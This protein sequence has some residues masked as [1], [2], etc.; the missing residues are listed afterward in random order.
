MQI[1]QSLGQRWRKDVFFRLW[2]SIVA[3]LALVS[4][5]NTWLNI[6]ALR[7][8][9]STQLNERVENLTNVLVK[10]LA[11]PLFD[12]N[13]IA[14]D[15]VSD[16]VA[17]D[18]QILSLQVTSP[19]GTVLVKS[20]S[21]QK[22]TGR[23]VSR[24]RQVT[25]VTFDKTYV[26]GQLAVFLSA[27]DIEKKLDW[28]IFQAVIS[29]VLL[30]LVMTLALFLAGRKLSKN[31][32][33]LQRAV[34]HLARGDTHIAL[35]NLGHEDQM[36]RMS[37]AVE[38]FRTT[39]IQ[40]RDVEHESATLL[41]EKSDI[42]GKLN[43]IYD[44]SN[45]AVMLLTERGFFDCN[46]RAMEMFGVSEKS[47]FV[48]LHPSDISPPAQPDG[49]TSRAA[50]EEKIGLAFQ[51]G[52]CRF[53]WLHAKRDGSVFPAEV[54]LSAFVYGGQ[55]VLQATVRDITARKLI[56]S[57]LLDL[58][59]ALESKIELRTQEIR[60]T[61]VLLAQSQ[62]T[63]QGI[64]D[65]ALDAVIR[66]NV[67]GIIVGWN[68]QAS[69]IFGWSAQEALGRTLHETIIPQQHRQRHLQGMARFL[70]TGQSKVIDQ[71]IEI[72]ALH[73]SG[74]EFP[75]E[76]ALTQVA[77]QDS[78][79]VEFCAFI[80]DI[81]QRKRAEEEIRTSLEKQR[82]L[83]QLKSRFVA[84]ASH[85]FRTP[86]ATILSSTDLLN[87]YLDRL[88][89]TERDGLFHSITLAVER[90][91]KMLEDILTIGMDDA[92]R[93][94]FNPAPMDIALFCRALVDEVAS[95]QGVGE[96][97]RSAIE[98][99]THGADTQGLFDATLM[100]HILEN[101][102]SNAQKYSPDGQM[103]DFTLDCGPDAFVFTVADRGIGVPQA[104]MPRL[105]ESFHRASNVGTIIGT[106]LGL[107][108]VKR[109]VTLHTGTIA[110]SSVLGEGTV[111]LV[112]IPRSIR[113]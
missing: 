103:I 89:P 2:T 90:M 36:G 8:D 26:V 28:Q 77:L 27:E 39:I 83:V 102:L 7:A 86:L 47:Q 66:A 50:S 56:E 42:A 65:T 76:L 44:G 61:L 17:L 30:V 3:S 52:E 20:G 12:I 62:Q 64:V 70:P 94:Q 82:E 53:E 19:D 105:F 35:P 21:G 109:S 5:V 1:R 96:S 98:F 24:Q 11:R 68:A 80:R 16:A 81:T 22:M 95:K 91:T 48:A 88:P 67:H 43:A 32:G 29:G 33:E 92:E 74:R 60:S 49:Q 15:S 18:P 58:N 97:M 85:E 38:R 78:G 34:D 41:A 113:V 79:Q 107:A 54:L 110:V 101:L 72:S 23:A 46:K 31:F 87:H 112:T 71:R 106:G 13:T 4:A 63:L 93:M 37:Q 6:E 108:I 45:D 57:E 59:N 55:R 111:F 69:N 84:M 73:R 75:I 51:T 10:T 14:L 25:Y 40:L 9:A 104:D 100:R 99:R